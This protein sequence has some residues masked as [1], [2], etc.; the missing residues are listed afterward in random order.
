MTLIFDSDSEQVL[1]SVVH[2]VLCKSPL[3]IYFAGVCQ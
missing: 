1:H 3:F 2:T